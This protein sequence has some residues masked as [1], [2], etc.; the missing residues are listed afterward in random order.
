[1]SKI[2][3]VWG[4]ADSIDMELRE[5]NGRWIFSLPPDLV[6]GQYAV[7]LF[8]VN[9]SDMLG[10]W[11]GIR[12]KN[13]S[14]G[15]ALKEQ[16]YS[17]KRSAAAMFECT[18][19]KYAIG[20]KVIIDWLVKTKCPFDTVV[21]EKARWEILHRNEIVDSGTAVVDIFRFFLTL[22]TKDIMF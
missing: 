17:L 7:Q 3:R 5:K 6:D 10:T 8:A 22:K 20:E 11:T 21:V 9:E 14:S 4:K 16:K 18:T 12:K 2:V 13:T 19:R 15:F 1:M